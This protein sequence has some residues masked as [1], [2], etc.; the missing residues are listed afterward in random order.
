M[1]T[2]IINKV[3]GSGIISIDLESYLPIS[4]VAYIDIKANLFQELILKEKDFRDFIKSNDWSVYQDKYVGVYCSSD[5]IIPT[6]AYMLIASALTSIAKAIYFGSPSEVNAKVVSALF[7][8]QDLSQY[9]DKRIVIKGCGDIKIGEQAF[10]TIANAL[11]P[12]AKAL[13]YGEPCS[14][15][16]IYKKKNN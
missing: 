4:E 8:Q 5:A 11:R 6:W 14:T 9:E 16:P 10:I 15:V 12:L 2:E 3:A 7:L 1:E 13:M